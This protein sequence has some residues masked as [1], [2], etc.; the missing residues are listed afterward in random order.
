M[1]TGNLDIQ[2][3]NGDFYDRLAEAIRTAQAEKWKC[4]VCDKPQKFIGVWEM[5]DESAMSIGPAPKY[6]RYIVYAACNRHKQ[7]VD[8]CE[9]A[10]LD[11]LKV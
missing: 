4:C 8:K 6:K 5:D 7:E 3:S 1:T 2:Q 11:S 10:I 9:D